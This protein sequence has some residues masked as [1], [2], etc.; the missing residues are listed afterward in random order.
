MIS[1]G[2][3]WDFAMAS[4]DAAPDEQAQ[5]QQDVTTSSSQRNHDRFGYGFSVIVRRIFPSYV[6]PSNQ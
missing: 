4:L 2:D 1:R 5:G 6:T 3:G